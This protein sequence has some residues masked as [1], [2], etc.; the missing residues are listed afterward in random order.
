MTNTKK[1]R[2]LLWGMQMMMRDIKL[3]HL[4][5]DPSDVD[6]ID[7]LSTVWLIQP[8]VAAQR[9][10][11]PVERASIGSTSDGS[12]GRWMQNDDNPF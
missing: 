10:M 9:L 2:K 11:P 4:P 3:F 1:R 5:D 12:S 6:P 7:A 8:H